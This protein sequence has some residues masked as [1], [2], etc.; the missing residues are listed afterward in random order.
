MYNKLNEHVK[1]REKKKKILLKQYILLELLR[2][3]KAPM[4]Y[5]PFMGFHYEKK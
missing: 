4:A 2:K 1:K 3:N 5:C